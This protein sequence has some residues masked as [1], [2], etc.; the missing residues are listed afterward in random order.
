MDRVSIAHIKK[1]IAIAEFDDHSWDRADKI[2]IVTYW[3]GQTAPTTRA[4]EVRLLWSDN[5]LYVRFEAQQA[6]ALIVSEKPDLTK[7]VHGLWERDVFE[8]F[9][10][11]DLSTANKYYEFE[12]APTGEWIDLAIEVTPEKRITDWEYASNMEAA[13]KIDGTQVV[14]LIKIPFDALGRTPKPGDVWL[15]NLFRCV[16]EG[17]DRGYLAW[18]PTRTKE[19]RFHVPDA[20]GEFEFKN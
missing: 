12:V 18:R 15:G 9:I 2:E 5:A 16:G 14:E 17:P 11:P 3:S 7:K 1:D 13:A 6:E 20:F 8:I 10:A 19:P 4:F